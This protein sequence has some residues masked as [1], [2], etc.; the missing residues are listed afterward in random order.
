MAAAQD[1]AQQLPKQPWD[2]D[3]CVCGEDRQANVDEM[4]GDQAGTGRWTDMA[5]GF[6][7]TVVGQPGSPASLHY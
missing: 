4:E 5:G 2:T 3:L 7:G 6:S 1:Y